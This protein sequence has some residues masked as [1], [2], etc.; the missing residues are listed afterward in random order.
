MDGKEHIQKDNLL[1]LKQYKKPISA[2]RD[3]ELYLY[4]NKIKEQLDYIN[5][6]HFGL[7]QNKLVSRGLIAGEIQSLNS[8]NVELFVG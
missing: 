6:K 5:I 1:I 8:F 3:Y 2:Y 7:V 4:Y